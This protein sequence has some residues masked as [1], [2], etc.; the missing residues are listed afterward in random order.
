M[1]L[2]QKYFI[3]CSAQMW[4]RSTRKQLEEVRGD[5]MLECR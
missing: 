3:Y 2:F 5:G 4:E 1:D